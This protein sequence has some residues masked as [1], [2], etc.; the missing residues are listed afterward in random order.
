MIEAFSIPVLLK[1][2]DWLFDE[3]SKILQERRERRK[4]QQE[5]EKQSPTGAAPLAANEPLPAD[6]IQSKDAALNQMVDE[7]VWKNTK[8]EVVHLLN[9]LEIHTS[10]YN[11]AKSQYAMWGRALVPSI[12]VNNLTEAEDEVA[13]TT[14]KLQDILS[15]AYGKKVIVPGS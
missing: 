6:V 1:A 11:L 13:K 3:C 4:D 12:V 2:V 5:A 8:D 15:K 14:Q 9:L 7:A 10:N